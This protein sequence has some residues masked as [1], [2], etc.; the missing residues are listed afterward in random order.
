[1]LPMPWWD[2]RWLEGIGLLVGS[3]PRTSILRIES[4]NSFPFNSN[5]TDFFLKIKWMKNTLYVDEKKIPCHFGERKLY[6]YYYYLDS[7]YYY[8]LGKGSIFVACKSL[9]FQK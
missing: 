2:I 3:P 8:V 9:I 6:I 4:N 7:N 1:M 5:S